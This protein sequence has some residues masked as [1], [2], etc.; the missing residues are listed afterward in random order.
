MPLSTYRP[1]SEPILAGDETV[2]LY[3]LT[4]NDV[5]TLMLGYGDQCRQAYEMFKAAG[6]DAPD[7]TAQ[8]NRTL[9]EVANLIPDLTATVIALSAREPDATEQAKSLPFTTQVDA[10]VKVLDLTLGSEGGLGNFLAVVQRAAGII[11]KTLPTPAAPLLPTVT[12]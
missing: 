9:I 3:P 10:L 1:R 6:G 7:L 5:S 2:M 12:P 4:V 8:V 11:N